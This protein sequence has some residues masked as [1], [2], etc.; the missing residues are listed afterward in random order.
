M[1]PDSRLTDLLGIEHPILQAPMLGTCTPELAAAV[2]HAGG[3]GAHACGALNA[4]E[5]QARASAVS[6]I[7]NA[8]VNLNFFV[9]RP[10]GRTPDADALNH[11]ARYYHDH[12]LGTPPA[13]PDPP[14]P[15]PGPD[16]IEVICRAAPRVVSFHFGLPAKDDLAKIKAA[17]CIV[18][19]TATTVAEARAL[20]DAGVDAII[21]Q[22]WE[23]GGHR[24]SHEPSLPGD[25]VGTLAL[26]PQIVDAVSVPVIAAGGIG[27]G[28]G[29]AAAFA[30]GASGVQMGT[31]FLKCDEAAT[32][33]AA[34]AR[35]TESGDAGTM[36]TDAVS[37]R[38]ARGART[39][40]AADLAPYAGQLPE[41][42]TLY[43]LTRPLL[44]A[45]VMDFSL[46]GQA[47][48]YARQMPVAALL[49]QLVEETFTQFK[50]LAGGG[51]G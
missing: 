5:V 32:S 40:F 16:V 23:A 21:A 20:E 42:P 22:G 15:A 24:G 43:T 49:E 9:V 1:W 45:G 39:D 4:E 26:V 50:N 10:E 31:V 27:D 17:G 12:D 44:E 36:V 7:T 48:V 47:G 6:Q 2:S 33:A 29:I 30:L 8:P 25:G 11:L 35:L 28:R 19:S 46:H 41:F 18:L 51:G 38:S 13:V 3:L 34:R 14:A 37:G